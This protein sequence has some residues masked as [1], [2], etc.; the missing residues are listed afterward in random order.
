M[1]RNIV[2]AAFTVV[3]LALLALQFASMGVDGG[4]LPTPIATGS[5]DLVMG[6]M[7]AGNASALERDDIVS[8]P[9]LGRAARVFL[10]TGSARVGSTFAIPVMR[11]GRRALVTV[12]LPA[13]PGWT[14]WLIAILSKLIIYCV[15][16]LV[17]WRGRDSA[18]TFFGIASLA[19]SVAIHPMPSSLLAPDLQV[20]YVII[21]RSFADVAALNL[22]LMVEYL[23]RASLPARWLL[24][25]RTVVIAGVALGVADN[26]SSTLGRVATG[27]VNPVLAV[28][29]PVAYMAVLAVTLVALTLAYFSSTGALRQRLRWIYVSTFVGFTGV[30]AYLGGQ[31]FDHPIPAY[32]VMNVTAIAIPIGYAYAILRHRVID[33][34]FA[35]NRAIVF[36][37]MTTLVVMAFA[38]LS[39]VLERA[40]VG[41]SESV[42]LQVAVALG[43]ALSFNA[44]QKRVESAI[45]RIFFARKHRA[46]AEL[47][48]LADEAPYVH[49]PDVLLDRVV[50]TVRRELGCAGVAV[51]QS[52]ADGG[53]ERTHVDGADVPPSVAVDDP[54]FVRLRTY[55]RDLDLGDVESALGAAGAVFPLAP[56]GRI[57]GAIVCGARSSEEPY[58]P[59]ERAAVRALAVRVAAALEALRARDHARL[60]KA[61]ADGAITGDA[62]RARAAS[63]LSAE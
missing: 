28:A 12:S 62:A 40:A 44:L 31:V 8:A 10:T 32:P 49:S 3:T 37:A 43:L 35:V 18:A 22:Y 4:I 5:C 38:L 59:D 16:A 56:Q 46:E 55:L 15:G 11:D 21:A 30:L 57:I 24:A 17:L 33:V 9:A 6:S 45:D 7:A 27:C 52:R 50:R 29:H 41:P 51:Y 60:V 13:M 14:F 26:V 47:A 25:L 53:Y 1:L 58:D 36:T 54:A 20:W 34:G 61:I 2:A 42:A 48:R 63:L 19:I 23:S 39:G